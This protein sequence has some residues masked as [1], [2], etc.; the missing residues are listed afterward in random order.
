[1]KTPIFM[2]CA[3]AL[4]APAFAQNTAP[5]DT[6]APAPMAA[7]PATAAPAAAAPTDP[8][9]II[10]TEFPVYDKDANGSLNQA[11]MGTWLKA[12]KM[13]SPDAKPMAPA[14]ETKWLS[15]SFKDADADKSASVTVAELTSYLT[16]GT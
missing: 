2:G 11:E 16:K 13:A 14:D 4:A 3:L 15:T 9:G 5:A 6:A 7:E 8:A 12:L 10:K 1:M